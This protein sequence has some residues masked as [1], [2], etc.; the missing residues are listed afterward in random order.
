MERHACTV[1]FALPSLASD[2][3]DAQQRRPRDLPSLA[4]GYTGG[5]KASR[6]TERAFQTAFGLPLLSMWASTEDVGA[7]DPAPSPGPLTA[8][9]PDTKVRLVD[10]HGRDVANGQPGEMWL[11]S[12]ATTPG[13]WQGPGQVEPLEDGW[14]RSGDLMRWDGELLRYIGRTKDV[15]VRA[16]TNIAPGEV[17]DALLSADGISD[18][19]VVGLPDERLGQRVVA[20]IVLAEGGTTEGALEQARILLETEKV[21]EHVVTID[22]LPRTPAGK[23][24]RKALAALITRANEGTQDPDPARIGHGQA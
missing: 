13:Y 20:A 4:F 2:V 6:G 23:V 24:D 22:V 15:I 12:P 18:A 3:A 8:V 10:E 19:G 21:P 14:F 7:T 9:R 17:E 11:R 16:G 1:F 5:D